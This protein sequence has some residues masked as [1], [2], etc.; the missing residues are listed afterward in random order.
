MAN[1]L[2]LSADEIALIKSKVGP[3]GTIGQYSKAYLAVVDI[4][5]AHV[6]Q[7]LPRPRY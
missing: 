3:A 4:N 1:Q 5:A 6:A 7:G 2:D